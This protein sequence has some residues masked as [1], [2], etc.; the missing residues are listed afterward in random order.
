MSKTAPQSQGPFLRAKIIKSYVY[1]SVILWYPTLQVFSGQF[2]VFDSIF[3][4]F[5]PSPNHSQCIKP[6]QYLLAVFL[7]SF[8]WLA[9]YY[10]LTYFPEIQKI[11]Y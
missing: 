10:I 1:L 3:M 2:T 4:P 7:Q 8:Y 9:P 11:F 6:L 5:I